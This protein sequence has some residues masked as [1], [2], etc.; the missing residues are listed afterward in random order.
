VAVV[1]AAAMTA[2]RRPLR[3]RV[4]LQSPAPKLDGGFFGPAIV[5]RDE[6]LE[7]FQGFDLH[8][9]E[10]AVAANAML[11]MLVVVSHEA[12]IRDDQVEARLLLGRPHQLGGQLG[13]V[14]DLERH[15]ANVRLVRRLGRKIVY[16]GLSEVRAPAVVRRRRSRLS[17]VAVGTLLTVVLIATAI[18]T[19]MIPTTVVLWIVLQVQ[20]S[21]APKRLEVAAER[22]LLVQQ[23]R[24][25]AFRQ[26]LLVVR[27]AVVG[28]AL[29]HAFDKKSFV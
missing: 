11:L 13:V 27:G 1:A 15:V 10:P 28:P 6:T 20:G 3:R 29:H 25:R 8:V 21:L 9:G 17:A 16:A 26:I 14:L 18:I 23:R 12:A 7:H 2:R 24:P 22:Q 5:E 19:A 4:E